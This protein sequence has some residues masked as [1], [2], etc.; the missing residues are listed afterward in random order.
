M[1]PKAEDGMIVLMEAMMTGDSSSA[2]LAQEAR[3]QRTLVRDQTLPKEISHGTR[4]QFEQMGIVFGEDQD[5]LFVYV[6]LPDGWR[7]ERTDHSMW[8]RLVDDKNRRRASIFYKAACYDR[9]AD[10]QIER[11][12]SV[13]VE[14]VCGYDE[15]NYREHPWHCI[16]K[17]CDEVTWSSEEQLESE[18]I[19]NSD[20]QRKA[21]LAWVDKRKN[22][23]ELGRAWL[24]E[25][26]P[27]WL[28]PCAYWDE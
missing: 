14:P 23:R 18:P 26:Y 15:P 9:R 10:M 19:G 6:S 5:D 22:L 27:D 21:W 13:R 11:R 7:K 24:E 12:F 3:G 1:S 25:H 28:N 17:D 16:V 20:E 8:S 4:K 2:I